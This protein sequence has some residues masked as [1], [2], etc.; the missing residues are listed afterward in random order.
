MRIRKLATSF[1]PL[2][3]WSFTSLAW[4]CTT[5]CESIYKSKLIQGTSG[6]LCCSPSVVTYQIST[7]KLRIIWPSECLCL[8]SPKWNAMWVYMTYALGSTLGFTHTD[9]EMGPFTLHFFSYL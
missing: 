3:S 1:L 4:L 2:E 6:W 9:S 7:A 5:W 8:L